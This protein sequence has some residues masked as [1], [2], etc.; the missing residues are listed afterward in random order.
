MILKRIKI[1]KLYG[2]PNFDIHF[3][4]Q[5]CLIGINGSGKSSIL[6]IIDAF[7]TKKISFLKKLD[8][9]KILFSFQDEKEEFEIEIQRRE[10]QEL[11]QKNNG[12][13]EEERFQC[14]IFDSRMNRY[15]KSYYEDKIMKIQEEIQGLNTENEEKELEEDLKFYK[16]SLESIFQGRFRMNLSKNYYDKFMDKIN[17]WSYGIQYIDDRKK[18]LESIINKNISFIEGENS[19]I[20]LE[21]ILNPIKIVTGLWE[22]STKEYLSNL[23]KEIKDNTIFQYL[24]GINSFFQQTGK[25]VYLDK[26]N[27]DI[28]IRSLLKGGDIKVEDLSSGE[29]ELLI[30]YTKLFF[31]CKSNT[32][33]LLDEPERSLHIEWQVSLGEVMGKILQNENNTTSQ[34]IIAT[35]SP[36]ILQNMNEK[37]IIDMTQSQGDVNEHNISGD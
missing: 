27:T 36:F 14:I 16:K 25:E 23:I 21:E 28:H 18:Y 26:E 9:E 35:H 7:L 32:I 37:G 1:D 34:L 31:E 24:D 22:K 19:F 13:I 3:Q 15:M 8:Y 2:Y 4:K 29:T 11:I 17:F 20:S 30:V 5:N 33:I 6:R 10:N 12:N